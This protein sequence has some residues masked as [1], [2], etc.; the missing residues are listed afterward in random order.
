MLLRWFCRNWTPLNTSI[1]PNSRAFMWDWLRT[2]MWGIINCR[3]DERMCWRSS[4]GWSENIDPIPVCN[5]EATIEQ[6]Q[7]VRTPMENTTYK[8]STPCHWSERRWY[9]FDFCVAAAVCM[10]P[11]L[12][13]VLR[14]ICPTQF[15]AATANCSERWMNERKKSLSKAP[16]QNCN[17]IDK[18]STYDP[19]VYKWWVLPNMW[20]KSF[21]S[22]P[23][24]FRSRVG[25]TTHL[26]DGLSYQ[27]GTQLV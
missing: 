16:F 24:A 18:S 19:T 23:G 11:L 2:R 27:P 14:L 5:Y 26:H 3:G 8:N 21:T 7:H 13:I 17:V 25:Q 9:L 15:V 4:D 20:R 1:W 22:K 12:F 10:G 6:S